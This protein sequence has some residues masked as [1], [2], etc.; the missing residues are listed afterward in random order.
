VTSKKSFRVTME[1]LNSGIVLLRKTAVSENNNARSIHDTAKGALRRGGKTLD[2]VVKKMRVM[3]N[4]L[5]KVKLKLNKATE[6]CSK[7]NSERD[8]AISDKK[9]ALDS[10]KEKSDSLKKIENRLQ[11]PQI[12]KVLSGGFAIL[13]ADFHPTKFTNLLKMLRISHMGLS[14]STALPF[15]QFI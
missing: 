15:S 9:A 3:E 13:S 12:E 11:I 10:L 2:D 14:P 6:K 1:A 8:T 5:D 4:D 7:A